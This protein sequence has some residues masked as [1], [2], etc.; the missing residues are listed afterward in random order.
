MSYDYILQCTNALYSSENVVKPNQKQYPW[1]HQ[2][3]HR[4]PTIDEC[5]EDDMVCY[6]EANSQYKRDR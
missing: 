3:F 2:K 1:Y 5:Y 6:T 4:V